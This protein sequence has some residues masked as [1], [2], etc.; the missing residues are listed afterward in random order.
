MLQIL[1]SLPAVP[2]NG[3]YKVGDYCYSA[4]HERHIYSGKPLSV[5]PFD[6]ADVAA[7]NALLRKLTTQAIQMVRAQVARTSRLD[8]VWLPVVEILPIPDDDPITASEAREFAPPFPRKRG[9]PRKIVEEPEATMETV[10]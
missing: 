4:E 9:R 1:L 3:P 2:K 5:D 6:A 10:T 8:A 7:F